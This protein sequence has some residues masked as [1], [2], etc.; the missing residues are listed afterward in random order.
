MES[1]L[2]LETK[3]LNDSGVEREYLFRLYKQALEG[4]INTA[5]GWRE[6]EQ[7]AR[8]EASY[9]SNEVTVLFVASKVAGYHVIRNSPLR[10]H[11]ALLLLE[12][13][14]QRIG[15]GREIMKNIHAEALQSSQ[16]VTLSSFKSN[17]SALSFYH[18]LGYRQISE[19]AA[20]VEL[21]WNKETSNK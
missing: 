8:F 18:R 19:D 5:F 3:P 4:Y 21:R 10:K 17:S 12:P 1:L 11:V 2:R 6:E 14:F 7:R 9:P 20:F 15:L 13:E 16:E